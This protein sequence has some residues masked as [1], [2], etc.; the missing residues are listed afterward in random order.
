MTRPTEYGK[1]RGPAARRLA[2]R[3]VLLLGSALFIGA[4]GGWS[5]RVTAAD[6]AAPLDA[7]LVNRHMGSMRDQL[8]AARGEM[9]LVRL[10]LLRAN[11][12]IENSAR[13]KIPADLSAAIYDVALSEGIDPALGYQLIKIESQFKATARSNMGAFG[14][15]QIQPATARFYQADVTERQLL[16]RDTNLRIGFRFLGD[17]LRKY[18]G[19][20]HLALLAYNRGPARVEQILAAGGNPKNG[21][22]DAVLHGYRPTVG[23]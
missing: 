8:E 16:D 9:A 17:L 11:V 2:A 6:E 3:G 10:Q 5:R 1:T 13:Y 12:V 23:P 14:Y 15:T 7:A 19:D 20:K 18:D 22:S 4:V 21:Y